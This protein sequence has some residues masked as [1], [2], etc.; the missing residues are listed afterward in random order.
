MLYDS[1][2]PVFKGL[3]LLSLPLS[4]CVNPFLVH[5]VL[6]SSS[7]SYKL[8]LS[9]ALKCSLLRHVASC[10]AVWH[11]LFVFFM[12][13]PAKSSSLCLKCKQCFVMF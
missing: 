8:F 6:L 12:F 10:V 1:L 9:L 5:S 7:F 11:I 4:L 2:S 13:T 3:A